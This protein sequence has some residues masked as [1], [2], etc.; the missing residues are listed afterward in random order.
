MRLVV[1]TYDCNC[2]MISMPKVAI[3]GLGRI[4]R[5]ALKI[6]LRYDTV[7]GRY[8]RQVVVEADA[9]VIDGHRVAV[10]AE[11]DP[12]ARSMSAAPSKE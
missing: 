11:R 3:N 7:Y 8:H 12:V 6:L 5:A 10:L 1:Q 9:L 2:G 4:G